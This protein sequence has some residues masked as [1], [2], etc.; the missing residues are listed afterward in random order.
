MFGLATFAL[1]IEP[2][3][4]LFQIQDLPFNGKFALEERERRGGELSREKDSIS[5]S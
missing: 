3:G 4:T 1:Q 2:A 5:A